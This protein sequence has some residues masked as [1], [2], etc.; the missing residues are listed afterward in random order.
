MALFL[1]MLIPGKRFSWLLIEKKNVLVV[2]RNGY[3]GLHISTSIWE[4]V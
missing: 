4:I 1:G 3:I 2:L